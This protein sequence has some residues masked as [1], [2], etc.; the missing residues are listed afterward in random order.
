MITRGFISSVSNHQRA[1]PP[2]GMAKFR[3]GAMSK[4]KALAV[5][6]ISLPLLYTLFIL[7]RNQHS[8]PT[9][10]FGEARVLD[11]RPRNIVN[12]LKLGTKT[13]FKG[14]LW[15]SV[16]LFFFL[17]GTCFGILHDRLFS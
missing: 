17:V 1:P 2:M 16:F 8:D 3:N 12:A 14:L 13:V 15:I 9:S 6:L 4:I 11:V 5:S 10:D 7:H